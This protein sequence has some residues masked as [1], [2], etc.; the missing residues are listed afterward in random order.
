MKSREAYQ[1]KTFIAFYNIFQVIA[2]VIAIREF[3][4]AGFKI[5]TILKCEKPNFQTESPR[6]LRCRNLMLGLKA[7]ELLETVIFVLRKKQNQVS[8]LHVYHHIS[9]FFLGW[10]FMKYVSGKNFISKIKN[11]NQ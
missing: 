1:M 6:M 11:H 2:C 8:G 4:L 10:Y 3:I 9:T 5:E 7:I